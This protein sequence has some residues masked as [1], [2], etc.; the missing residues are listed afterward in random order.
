MCISNLVYQFYRYLLYWTLQFVIISSISFA[1]LL[2]HCQ[3]R[4]LKLDEQ[5]RQSVLQCQKVVYPFD[6]ERNE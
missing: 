2:D 3:K 5:F 1:D 6:E 4:K